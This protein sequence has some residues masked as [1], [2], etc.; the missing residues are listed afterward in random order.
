VSEITVNLANLSVKARL[1]LTLGVLSLA[2]AVVGVLG[3]STAHSINDDLKISY[4]DNFLAQAALGEIIS[5]QR[6]NTEQ[7]M[8]AALVSTPEAAGAS[9]AHV[10]QNRDRINELWDSYAAK[11]T[12]PEE[13]QLADSFHEA[14]AR[15]I[16]ANNA[17]LGMAEA[18][19]K[20][21]AVRIVDKDVQPLGELA[22]TAGDKLYALQSRLAAEHN[23]HAQKTFERATSLIIGAVALAMAVCATLAWL[24]VRSIMSG[25]NTAMAVTARI[26]GGDIGRE[27]HIEDQHEFG[28]LLKSLQVMDLK[29]S[30]IVGGVRHNADAVGAAAKQ[31]SQGNDDLSSRTQQQAA[32]LEETAASMEEMAATVKQNADNAK[33][34]NQLAI[35]ARGQAD[36]GGTVVQQAV[37]A[38]SAINTS[39]R[40]IAD[41]ISVIDD[42]A[43]QTNLL[44]LNA[45]VEAARAGEQGRGFAV[46]ASEV[47]NLA[48]RSAT[49]AK[50]IKGL[51]NDSVEKVTVGTS[52][53]D[54]SGK[55]I[56]EI[57]DSVKK[58][59][60]I[61]AEIAAASEEQANGVEQVNKAVTQMDDATQQNAALVE[62]AA[63][64]A[65]SMQQQTL[66]LVASVSYFGSGGQRSTQPAAAP[67]SRQAVP[68]T[69]FK[70]RSRPATPAPRREP[71]PKLAKVSGGGNAEW[72]EF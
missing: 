49:A 26:A 57:M 47:R 19:N 40:K 70:A 71:A 72:Q 35:S 1:F 3:Y 14:R 6:G 8:L 27:I 41:I 68:V 2:S 61:V 24:L 36:Q 45:A 12:L 20:D 17:A 33:Q 18:G 63:A 38:M 65:K 59:T 69:T 25:L 32:S 34:A 67:P 46:V 53:V 39:S 52:L 44:A 4:E 11:V 54:E 21:E 10:L 66:E 50:E 48:Q 58:V 28:Q 13:K 15:L 62:E 16:T 30:E 51:I 42:I 43:F 56:A 37:N 7:V 55:R 23:A 22:L 64:A 60:D 9:R 29:L 5:R 31:I